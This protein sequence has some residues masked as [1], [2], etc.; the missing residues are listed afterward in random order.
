[1]RVGIKI[2]SETTDTEA[3]PTRGNVSSLL[4]S[5]PKGRSR[6]ESIFHIRRMAGMIQIG[7]GTVFVLFIP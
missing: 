3:S 6:L 4:P 1:M 5:G 7:L 2:T